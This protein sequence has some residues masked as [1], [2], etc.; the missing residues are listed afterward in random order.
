MV[1]EGAAVVVI[2]GLLMVMGGVTMLVL[3]LSRPKTAVLRVSGDMDWTLQ[4]D[5]LR[6]L[7][8]IGTT[9]DDALEDSKVRDEIDERLGFKRWEHGPA[10]TGWLVNMHAVRHL[11][12]VELANRER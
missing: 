8:I 3:Q 1:V 9:E 2:A 5:W 10:R 12:L 7:T 6:M 11:L 4:N